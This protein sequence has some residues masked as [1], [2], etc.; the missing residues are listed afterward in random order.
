MTPTQHR[1]ARLA[2]SLTRYVRG[3]L[4]A[5]TATLLPVEC[6]LVARLLGDEMTARTMAGDMGPQARESERHGVSPAREEGA[7]GARRWWERPHLRAMAGA[8]V[9][10][11]P[12]AEELGLLAIVAGVALLAWVGVLLVTD[13]RAARR[14][15]R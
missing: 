4:D 6:R 1:A 2:Q 13:V 11:R 12:T 8:P 9:T 7:C 14:G 3:E 15:K 5:E 10:V